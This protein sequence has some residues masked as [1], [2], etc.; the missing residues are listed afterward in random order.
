MGNCKSKAH[1]DVIDFSQPNGV[2]KSVF[3]FDKDARQIV[4]VGEDAETAEITAVG[5]SRSDDTTNEPDTGSCA[6]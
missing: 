4:F 3:R 5:S 2:D 6:T 1:G